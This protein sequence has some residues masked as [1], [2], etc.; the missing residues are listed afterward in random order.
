MRIASL[1]GT[2]SLL[3]CLSH[4]SSTSPTSPRSCFRNRF[5]LDPFCLF[6]TRNF[7]CFFF[8]LLDP[9]I[10]DTK[11]KTHVNFFFFY[12]L[13]LCI[14]SIILTFSWTLNSFCFCRLWLCYEFTSLLLS[15]AVEM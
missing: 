9:T 13:S 7:V 3:Y 12:F 5:I 8:N 10:Y 14:N 11:F 1:T 2:L 15:A 4:S 6:R